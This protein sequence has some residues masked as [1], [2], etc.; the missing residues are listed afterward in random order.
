MSSAIT[1]GPRPERCQ[2]QAPRKSL[3]V[4]LEHHSS[5]AFRGFE[6]T[7]EGVP[8][9][10]YTA[11]MR[12]LPLVWGAQPKLCWHLGCGGHEA[13]PA[14]RPG[15]LRLSLP[16][17]L[18]PRGRHPGPAVSLVTAGLSAAA[19]TGVG[20]TAAVPLRPMPVLAQHPRRQ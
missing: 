13:S 16:H 11:G 15:A 8:D 2:P 19:F 5:P 7:P 1:A 12:C 10:D 14:A 3:L 20:F 6:F 9:V 18:R 17:E 4:L